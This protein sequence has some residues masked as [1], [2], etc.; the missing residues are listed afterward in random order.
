MCLTRL[1]SSKAIGQSFGRASA[2]QKRRE[3]ENLEIEIKDYESYLANFPD[4][5]NV[6]DNY[7]K[8]KSKFELILINESEGARIRAGQKWAQEGEKNTKFFL[9]L[10]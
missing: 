9:N 8:A 5:L 3:K 6:L 4:D 10:E 7:L 2:Q 1:F